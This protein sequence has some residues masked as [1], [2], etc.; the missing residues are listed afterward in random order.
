MQLM[1][2]SKWDKHFLDICLTLAKN[3]NC[4]S[5]KI[6]AILVRDKSIIATGY[7]GSP[8]GFRHC[9]DLEVNKEQE[10]PKCPRRILGI[11]SG[12]RMELC[13]ATHAEVNCICNAARNGVNIKD[14]TMYMTCGIP[15]SKCLAVLLN[16]GVTNLVVTSLEFYDEM[17]KLMIHKFHVRQYGQEHWSIFDSVGNGVPF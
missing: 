2:M 14:S 11:E 12:K 15:C 3:S 6:G 13:P 9:A 17:S 5:R 4:L 8:R 10:F 7:N 1:K 16:A